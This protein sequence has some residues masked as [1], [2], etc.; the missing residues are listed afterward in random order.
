MKALDAVSLAV[1]GVL[2]F[3]GSAQG[4]VAPNNSTSTDSAVSVTTSSSSSA[5]IDREAPARKNWR[6][7]MAKQPASGEG[8]SCF[9]AS[10]PN[11]VWEAVAC[12][13]AGQPTSHPTPKQVQHDAPGPQ[14]GGSIGDYVAVT[15]NG[16][17][18]HADGA[19]SVSG[20]TTETNVANNGVTTGSNDYGL[21]INTNWS[22]PPGQP[23]S[24]LLPTATPAAC[25]GQTGCQVWQQFI[26]TTDF[27][28]LSGPNHG[29]LFMQYWLFNAKCPDSTWTKS[30]NNCF[31]NSRLQSVPAVPVTDLGEVQLAANALIGGN[32][33]VYFAYKDEAWA[34][35]ADDGILDIASIWQGVEFNVVGNTS[36]SQAY[37][38]PGSV[39][40]VTVKIYD[41]SDVPPLCLNDTDSRVNG[42]GTTG[43]TNN[44]D[45]GPCTA[46]LV[47]GFPAIEF[48]EGTQ[49]ALGNALRYRLTHPPGVVATTGSIGLVSR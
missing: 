35:Y 48:L 41:G 37:F 43:E 20:V 32:D 29:E 47:E 18:L 5:E 23:N 39:I 44:L 25:Q 17:I 2:A 38:N 3:V 9:H 19:F 14:E 21:Q 24:T 30:G 34:V 31:K 7:T 26:Y 36:Y 42:V 22:L 12:S 40:D 6:E 15:Q 49:P 10:Y 11:Y 33:E 16:L 46:S 13:T 28:G 27:N 8:N 1:I 45:L 4:G